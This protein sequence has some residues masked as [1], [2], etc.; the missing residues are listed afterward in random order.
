M[1]KMPLVEQTEEMLEENGWATARYHGCFDI[2]AR[3][4]DI[5]ILKLLTNVDAFT[6]QQASSLKTISS[7]LDAASILVGENTRAERLKPGV[8]YGRFDVPTVNFETLES[9]I[10]RSIL[11]RI[12]RDRGGF[13]VE[14]DSEAL[15]SARKDKKITQAEL[16]EAAGM[17]KKSVWEHERRDIRM[18][19][20]FAETLEKTLN[21]RIIKF[22]D[23]LKARPEASPARPKNHMER[24]VGSDLRKLGFELEFVR[25]APFDILAR[26]RVLVISDVE[27]NRKKIKR[28]APALSGFVSV[29]RKPA[30]VITEKSRESEMEG[31]PIIERRSLEGFEKS[32]DVIR[33]A[34][35]VKHN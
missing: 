20:D 6:E 1:L 15:R 14:I 17:S 27:P 3:K 9:L 32:S 34:K 25:S 12:Y 4:R 26:E 19:L 10:V 8:V 35:R 22:I 11:P 28:R 31:I 30:V 29:V 23:V 2:A 24:T 7:S 13:Y 5:L 21:G 33:L 18:V 16:A